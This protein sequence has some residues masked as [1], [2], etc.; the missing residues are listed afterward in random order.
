MLGGGGLD[1]LVVTKEDHCLSSFV[2]AEMS[3]LLAL[4]RRFLVG[5][6]EHLGVISMI[7]YIIIPQ[8]SLYNSP[9]KLNLHSACRKSA[10]GKGSLSR[11]TLCFGKMDD[12]VVKAITH[13]KTI[14][15]SGDAGHHNII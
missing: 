9:N 1:I 12:R 6:R 5:A 8:I 4:F 3:R 7:V 13:A 15:L 11:R 14:V 2:L 10:F